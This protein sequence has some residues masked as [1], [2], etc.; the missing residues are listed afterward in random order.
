MNVKFE[1]KVIV[2]AAVGAV[3]LWIIDAAVDTVVFKSSS[4]LESLFP[5]MSLHELYFRS[6]MVTGLLFFGILFARLSAKRRGIEDR[7][8]NLVELT[9]DIITISDKDG[10]I[11]FINDAGCRILERTREETIG[12]LCTDLLHPDD[13]EQACDRHREVA[14]L[15]LDTVCVENRYLTKSG[16]IIPVMHNVRLLRSERG[17][18]A[19]MQGIARDMSETKEKERE[20]H[21]A[22]VRAEDEKARSESIVAAIGDGISI[23]D[24]N[25]TV[26]YQNAVH[27]SMV[28]GGYAGRY[29]YE[30]YTQSKAQCDACPV[31]EVFKDGRIHTVEKTVVWDDRSLTIEITA[32][33]L[34]DAAGNIIAGI[35]AVRDISERRKAEE[36]LKL[37]SAAI[38]EAM[39]GIQIVD[40]R[41]RVV[42]SNKAVREIYGFSHEDLVGTFVGDMNADREFASKVILPSIREQGCWSGEVTVVHKNGKPFPVWLA[43]SVVNGAGGSPMAMISITRDISERKQAEEIMKRHHE[44]LIKIVEERTLELTAANE[45]LR[46]E[47]SDREKMEHELLKTQKLESLGILAGGI[48]H[49]FNNLLASIM[50]NISLALLDLNPADDIYRQLEAAERA[51][52]RAQD[53]TR[54]LLT[55]SKGGEPVKR[56]TVISELIKEAAGFALRGARIRYDF[57]FPE[58]LWLVEI[59]EGQISQVIHNLVINADHAMPEGGTI[60]IRCDNSIVDARSGLPLRP[61]DYVRITIQDHGIGISREHLPKIFDPYFTTKQKGS[62]L[63]LATSYSIVKKHGGHIIAESMLGVGTTFTFYLPATKEAQAR[64]TPDERIPLGTGRILIMDDEEEVRITTGEILKR[65]GYTIELTDDG[66]RA[67]ECYREALAGGRPFD[68]VIMDL[69][70]PGGMGGKDVVLKLREMDPEVN[71]IVSSGYSNDPIMADFRKY[72]FKGMVTKPYRIR[73]L[74]VTLHEVLKN[75][76]VKSVRKQ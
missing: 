71:A 12:R 11:V 24:R 43:T 8:K 6:L 5:S 20:L 16:K 72:G 18:F 45:S 58:G 26:M 49:D 27:K 14:N 29:C 35:E 48:A 37:F 57:S 21:E 41:G 39:D 28:G 66:A 67:I 4:F 38:E 42:Y 59:D 22:I 73:D 52:L 25:L 9:N 30:A 46:R 10:N 34:T 75:D 32:S 74:G 63:G 19:G 2:Y 68:A 61:G 36:Q 60:E 7:Y 1:H 33:P 51:S 70:V 3:S 54:Q 40:M 53:L 56:S 50:G 23:V 44:Q 65:L 31:A 13:R 15:T 17:E 69:T 64:T 47:I 62:G 55:F 76:K